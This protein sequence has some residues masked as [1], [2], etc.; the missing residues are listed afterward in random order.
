MKLSR[1]V[2]KWSEGDGFL[3][4]TV[5]FIYYVFVNNVVQTVINFTASLIAGT[6]VF[7][8]GIFNMRFTLS[9]FGIYIILLL[10]M[11]WANNYRKHLGDSSRSALRC[12]EEYA[13]VTFRFKEFLF[14]LVLK[15]RR[16]KNKNTISDEDIFK[17]AAIY[18]CDSIY[19]FLCDYA[20][21]NKFKITVFQQ[22]EYSDGGRYTK[23]VA[24]K[25]HKN[26]VPISYRKNF[27]LYGK[28]QKLSTPLFSL[29][30][31]E[32]SEAVKIL[33]CRKKV[34]RHFAKLRGEEND[35]CQL[36]IP[37]IVNEKK[38]GFILQVS[39]HEEKLLGDEDNMKDIVDKYLLPY[40]EVLKLAYEQKRL[41]DTSI[42]IASREVISYAK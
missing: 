38:V 33:D 27:N 23:M 4:V 32:E 12:L 31:E 28:R 42:E 22:F 7:R 1:T 20:N 6:F 11:A 15:A 36:G 5:K 19:E 40:R 21:N 24:Y 30:F 39:S 14:E 37:G 25:T 13:A 2:K 8:N 16:S 34:S 26:T 9:F 41:I 35:T 3:A 17:N 10:L 29:L 18:V